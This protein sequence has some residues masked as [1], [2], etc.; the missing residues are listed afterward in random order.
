MQTKLCPKC[1]IDKNEN[2]YTPSSFA[3]KRG[4]CRGCEKIY[5]QQYWQNNRERLLAE[6][7][8]R[9][10]NRT[11]EEIIADR[12][13]H[14][15]YYQEN[16]E[17]LDAN[18]KIYYNEHKDDIREYKQEYYN[19][20]DNKQHKKEQDRIYNQENKGKINAKQRDRYH[21]DPTYKIRVLA[22]SQI[23]NM[24]KS[25]G[26]SKGGRSFLQYVDWEP[27]ELVIHIEKQFE[28]WMTWNNQGKYNSK[29]WDDNDQTT[30]KWQLDHIIPHSDLPYDNMEH[31]NF[32]K[33][34]A[35]SN[36][37]PL[38]AKQNLLDGANRT[39]HLN[40]RKN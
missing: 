37:R 9:Q 33:A 20:P 5:R 12:I 4:W 38:S 16:K 25:Q 22:T 8:I 7:K 31:P 21:S 10:S 28:T 29:T 14:S 17:Q 35:L 30:W 11:D 40:K 26:S 39:R 1:K 19:N 18:H 6:E 15:E 13:Y 36:L 3:R 34:W 32:K 2:E 24:L 27:E 23:T